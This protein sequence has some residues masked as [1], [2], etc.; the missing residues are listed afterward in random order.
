MLNF[1]SEDI[2]S[3]LKLFSLSKKTWIFLNEG[4]TKLP[5]RWQKIYYQLYC[6]TKF[7]FLT[8]NLSFILRTKKKE[9]PQLFS[10]QFNKS[11]CFL[12]TTR[13][14]IVFLSFWKFPTFIASDTSP[15]LIIYWKWNWNL[16]VGLISTREYWW[17]HNLHQ[18]LKITSSRFATIS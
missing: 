13:N 17:N 4:F 1:I 12:I 18:K 6:L 7:L 11:L 3:F 16:N 10:V 9:K 2:K 5:E 8:K 14:P 15:F